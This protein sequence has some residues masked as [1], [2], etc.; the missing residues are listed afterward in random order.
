MGR[1]A[2]TAAVFVGIAGI[3]TLVSQPT[4]EI[5]EQRASRNQ[6][7]FITGYA[8]SILHVSLRT[9]PLI[10]FG[11][12]IAI[13][14]FNQLQRINSFGVANLAGMLI[15]FLSAVLLL[16]MPT[17][18]E[19]PLAY[20]LL[21]SGAPFG[22]IT[23]VLFIGPAVNLPSLLVVARAAGVRSSLMLAL[24]TGGV[25]TATNWSFPVECGGESTNATTGTR[26]EI[27]SPR[28]HR[29]LGRRQ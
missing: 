4:I 24:L 10:L 20:S 18:F 12:P 11:I 6:E 19:I 28:C 23:A 5:P 3:A 14:I 26:L 25:A 7:S 16:P 1:L 2:L 17:L 21:L 13:L 8:E 27:R 29:K 22:L 9:V 15:L